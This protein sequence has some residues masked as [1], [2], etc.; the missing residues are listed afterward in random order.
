MTIVQP[1]LLP[2]LFKSVGIDAPNGTLL[3]G[4]PECGK[5]LLAKAVTNESRANFISVKDLSYSTKCGIPSIHSHPANRS[6]SMWAKA[7]EPFAE[8][9]QEPTLPHPVSSSSTNLML[10]Y[11][12]ETTR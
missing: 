3:W 11:H 12:E 4:P 9:F 5:T 2:G 7:N 8:Y 1:I 10:S 6:I